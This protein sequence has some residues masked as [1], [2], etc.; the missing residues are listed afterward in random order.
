MQLRTRLVE[1]YKEYAEGGDYVAKTHNES[2]FVAIWK[3]IRQGLADHS[4]DEYLENLC[5]LVAKASDDAMIQREVAKVKQVLNE[6]RH[7]ESKNV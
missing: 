3:I 4:G 6:I 5:E 2:T 7:N 1:G